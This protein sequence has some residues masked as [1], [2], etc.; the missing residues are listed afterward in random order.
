MAYVGLVAYLLSWSSWP[1]GLV[2]RLASWSTGLLFFDLL[3]SLAYW[4]TR[5]L[6]SWSVCSL[7][8]F[9]LLV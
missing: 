7:G 9:A 5:L 1:L 3:A 4:F 2:G 6:V 8:L